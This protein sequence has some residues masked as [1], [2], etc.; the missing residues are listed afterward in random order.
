MEPKIRLVT[1]IPGLNSIED[2]VPKPA[3]KFLPEWWKTM[4]IKKTT[5]SLEGV[6]FGNAKV[7][8]SFPA[9]LSRGFIVPMWVDSILY[10]E[11]DTEGNDCWRWR[12]ADQKFSWQVHGSGQ[13]MQHA[14]HKY[15]GRE[16]YF[17]FK[18]TLP[19]YVF[20]DPGYSLY[21][22]PT[23]LHFNEDF[24]AVPGVR[25]TD[26]YHEMNIQLV[27]HSLK[28]E[29]FIPRGTPLAHFIPFKRE[30][31]DLEVQY[32]T[33]EDKEKIAA[34]K[35]NVSTK[36]SPLVAYREDVKEVNKTL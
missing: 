7:C 27:I 18:S 6:A 16:G 5:P 25:D 31:V 3:S 28:K 32:A 8:P 23:L 13:Y 21:Q 1:D 35:L 14:S 2:A 29:I 9:Y 11:K 36:F 4:P 17:V 10:V 34:H 33:E 24:S 26:V 20:T 30:T 22:L 15:L 19:W 12:T